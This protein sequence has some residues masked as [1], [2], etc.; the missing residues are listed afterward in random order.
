MCWQLLVLTSNAVVEQGFL[1]L[2][3]PDSKASWPVVK[4]VLAAYSG[5]LAFTF[6]LFPLPYHHNSFFMA[7]VQSRP[8]RQIVFR[9]VCTTPACLL[10]LTFLP[11][12]DGWA[13]QAAF[14]VANYKAELVWNFVRTRIGVG[15]T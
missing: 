4:Q 9:S 14:S 6:H 12:P 1:D 13:R 15:S 8:C 3:C 5:E 7:Q 11:L 2:Q 10:V